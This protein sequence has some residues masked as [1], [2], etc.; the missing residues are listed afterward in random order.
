MARTPAVSCLE[1]LVVILSCLLFFVRAEHGHIRAKHIYNL[2][3]I[4]CQASEVKNKAK[5]S[6]PHS[7][8]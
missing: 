1:M 5:Y 2:I 3:F 7:A 4:E 8:P 6:N